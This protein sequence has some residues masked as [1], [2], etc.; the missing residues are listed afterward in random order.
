MKKFLGINVVATLLTLGFGTASQAATFDIFYDGGEE[1]IFHPH[2]NF[3]TEN[4]AN[5]CAITTLTPD[6]GSNCFICADGDEYLETIEMD[7]SRATALTISF[8]FRDNNI[9]PADDVYVQY[10]DGSAW[11]SIY[12]LNKSVINEDNYFTFSNTRNNSGG[13]TQYFHSAFKLRFYTDNLTSGEDLR[14]DDIKVV[15]TGNAPSANAIDQIS[16]ADLATGVAGNC[17]QSWSLD[18]D[19]TTTFAYL[20]TANPPHARAKSVVFDG[21][22]SV[23]QQEHKS[24]GTTYYQIF[25]AYNEFGFWQSSANPTSFTTESEPSPSAGI[26]PNPSSAA[27]GQENQGLYLEYEGDYSWN[28]AKIYFGTISG[29]LDYVGKSLTQKISLPLLR[30]S[31]TYYWRVD[32]YNDQGNVTGTEWSF[33]TKAAPTATTHIDENFEDQVADNFTGP[34]CSATSQTS[35][36]GSWAWACNYTASE[37]KSDAIDVSGKASFTINFWW[38]DYQLDAGDVSLQYYNGTGWDTIKELNAGGSGWNQYFARVD[39]FSEDAQYFHSSFRWRLEV[40]GMTSPEQVGLDVVSFTSEGTEKDA[41]GLYDVGIK[42]SLIVDEDRGP[43]DEDRDIYVKVYYPKD[44]GV[45][46]TPLITVSHGGANGK[47]AAQDGFNYLSNY[48]AQS[49]YVVVNVRHRKPVW[50]YDNTLMY[51]RQKDILA[52]LN[53]A[54]SGTLDLGDF[55][56]FIDMTNIGAVG[57]SAG[58]YQ[59]LVLAG[60][61]LKIGSADPYT[62]TIADM[63]PSCGYDIDAFLS[64]SA[65]GYPENDYFYNSA[66][67]NSF[68]SIGINTPVMAVVGGNEIHTNGVDA[69]VAVDWR[70]TPYDFQQD[71]TS[72]KKYYV[73]VTTGEHEDFNDKTGDSAV[74]EDVRLFVKANALAF[75]D[76]F[77]GGRSREADIGQMTNVKVGRNLRK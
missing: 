16:P 66:T 41:L 5:T 60:A 42:Y 40:S 19:V 39:N 22:L 30:Y 77:I 18:S 12:E 38:Y 36:D 35:K 44:F 26:N 71:P 4:D 10:W 68:Y 1:T 25:R 72:N 47:T 6:E 76:N 14:L 9:D 2:D 63:C 28:Y 3:E 70:K 31:T 58:A 17:P 50:S 23:S 53:E 11:D 56:G 57:H 24:W 54:D 7:T 59:T 74:A 43:S 69:F 62:E 52:V 65:A 37:L 15:L 73:E 32:G 21:G 13:D 27:T 34:G 55:D 75:F 67:D 45:G 49:G 64:M 20:D 61:E 51:E 33:T 48:L 8:R 29:D 46:S